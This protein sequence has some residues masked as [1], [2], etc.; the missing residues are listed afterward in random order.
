MCTVINQGRLL[1]GINS[2]VRLDRSNSVQP[3]G[4]SIAIFKKG[5]TDHAVEVDVWWS[6]VEWS[7]CVML[8]G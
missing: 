4:G 3:C 6:G 1:S 2:L 5:H 7:G 8:C